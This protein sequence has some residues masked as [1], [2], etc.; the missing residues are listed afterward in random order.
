MAAAI[1]ETVREDRWEQDRV[2][3][4]A[5]VRASYALDDVCRQWTDLLAGGQIPVPAV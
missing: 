1:A 5:E 3:A 2:A 4:H